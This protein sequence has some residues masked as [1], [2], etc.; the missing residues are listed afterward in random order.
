MRILRLNLH[1]H[2]FLLTRYRSWIP[3][4]TDALQSSLG[5]QKDF[6]EELSLRIS[7]RDCYL[8]PDFDL[9]EELGARLDAMD[10]SG[11]LVLKR[12][13]IDP[14][15]LF[16]IDVVQ[17]DITQSKSSTRATDENNSSSGNN[18]TEVNNQQRRYNVTDT[19]DYLRFRVPPSLEDLEVLLY[20]GET[21]ARR[22]IAAIDELLKHRRHAAPNLKHISILTHPKKLSD[23]Q[24]E[25]EP[26]LSAVADALGVVLD[27]MPRDPELWLLDKR[28]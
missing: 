19:K 18:R 14:A 8:D 11:F 6:L 21:L 10:F 7:D 12:L 22:L 5:H 26:S 4:K 27:V 9:E 24:E 1:T 17:A 28:L 3:F 15:I 13:K 16:G 2:G 23:Y 20:G 25:M